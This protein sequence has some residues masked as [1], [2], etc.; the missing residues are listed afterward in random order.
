VMQSVAG[1]A[2]HNRV[3]GTCRVEALRPFLSAQCYQMLRFQRVPG[4]RI[5]ISAVP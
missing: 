2:G 5:F 1:V 3:E 4:G